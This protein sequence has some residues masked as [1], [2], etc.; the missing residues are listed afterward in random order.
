[1][2]VALVLTP[3]MLVRVS[4]IVECGLQKMLSSDAQPAP[5]RHAVSIDY[6]LQAQLRLP[7]ITVLA[8][9]GCFHRLHIGE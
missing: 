6:P 4:T 8:V 2:L 1:M 9:P 7:P 3:I 5:K